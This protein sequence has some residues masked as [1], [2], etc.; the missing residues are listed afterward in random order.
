MYIGGLGLD[1]EKKGF[2]FF[3][4]SAG[5]E[6]FTIWFKAR[7]HFIFR[8]F[9]LSGIPLVGERQTTKSIQVPSNLSSFYQTKA[10]FFGDFSGSGDGDYFPGA[11][12]TVNS[13]RRGNGIYFFWE[14]GERIFFPPQGCVDSPVWPVVFPQGGGPSSTGLLGS[15][16]NFFPLCGGLGGLFFFPPEGGRVKLFLEAPGLFLRRKRAGYVVQRP[17]CVFL[18][19]CS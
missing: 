19:G 6:G 3:R 1:G 18:R 4:C 8:C 13:S 11:K 10:I 2:P 14:L 5:R 15:P 12:E 16:V 7:L 9:P 17:C